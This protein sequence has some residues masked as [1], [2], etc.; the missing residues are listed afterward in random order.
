ML[1][2]ET[3]AR[4]KVLAMLGFG[5]ACC[6]AA[7]AQDMD[8]ETLRAKIREQIK[9][10]D[11]GAQ[12]AAN[13]RSLF[14]NNAQDIQQPLYPSAPAQQVVPPMPAQQPGQ[15]SAQ[16]PAATASA[17]A[18]D[19]E[20]PFEHGSDVIARQYLP[21][22]VRYADIIASPEF[23]GRLIG[24]IGHTNAIGDAAYNQQLSERR[25]SSVVRE[26]VQSGVPGDRLFA[27]GAGETMLKPDI[28]SVSEKNR[29]VEVRVLR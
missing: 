25:A 11:A 8:P 9:A 27:Q 2:I 4:M 29:R 23:A 16:P 21:A 15:T 26:L 20:V 22:L 17:S 12:P 3:M 18:I 10:L 24:I 14:L 7:V 5:L 13:G 6:T 28:P 19:L 1:G